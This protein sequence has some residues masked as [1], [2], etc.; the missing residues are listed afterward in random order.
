HPTDLHLHNLVDEIRHASMNLR[1][2][3][4]KTN[5]RIDGIEAAVN[6]LLRKNGRPGAELTT[7]D[8][9]DFARKSAIELCHTRRH[10][11]VPKDDGGTASGYAPNED[12]ISE[13]LRARKAMRTLWRCG[14]PNRLDA[15]ERKSLTSFAFGSNSF[16]LAPELSQTTLSCLA[17]PTDLTGQVNN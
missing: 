2:G 6:E 5:A 1:D 4:E 9:A 17:D 8:S 16:I 3:D 7:D 13:A 10:L 12:E 14:D 11:T 15:L